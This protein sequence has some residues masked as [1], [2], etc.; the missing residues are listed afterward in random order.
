MLVFLYL[1]FTF[2]FLTL[3]S[4]RNILGK[5]F[6]LEFSQGSRTWPKKTHIF[7]VRVCWDWRL[8]G[9]TLF[10]VMRI[11]AHFLFFCCTQGALEFCL[12]WDVAGPLLADCPSSQ[13]GGMSPSLVWVGP[14]EWK[15]IEVFSVLS[16]NVW[17]L[18]VRNY[19]TWKRKRGE[20][21]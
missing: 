18:F 6:N 1:A 13:E 3:I 15:V 14:S 4:L 7:C 5:E 21:Q 10:Q 2:K 19:K 8:T 17:W 9:N 20:R 16:S 12:E 11:S